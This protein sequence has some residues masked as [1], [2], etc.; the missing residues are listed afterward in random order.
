MRNGESELFDVLNESYIALHSI[1]L[2]NELLRLVIFDLG[3][4]EISKYTERFWERYKP[5]ENGEVNLC[6]YRY[7]SDLEAEIKKV[8]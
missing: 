3:S 7:L 8:A 6:F 5:N 1:N 4:W 2:N